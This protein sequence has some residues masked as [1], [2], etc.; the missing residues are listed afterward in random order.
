MVWLSALL[1]VMI[2]G[3]T[4]ALF[5]YTPAFHKLIPGYKNPEEFAAEREEMATQLAEMENQMER[6]TTYVASFRKLAGME[7]DSIPVFS[8]ARL[9]SM[10]VASEGAIIRLQE[11]EVATHDTSTAKAEAVR[12]L[13]VATKA[14]ESRNEPERQIVYVSDNQSGS[15]LH[16]HFPIMQ[17]LFS[18]ISGEIRKSF[19]EKSAHYGVDIVAE[20]NTLI[21]SVA[22]GFVIISEYS[23]DNG[24]VI[25]VASAENV[26]TFYKHN[27]RLLKD[28][29]TYVYA[30][31]PIA[32]IGN[33]GENSTGPHLHLELWRQGRPVD[34]TNYIEF[35]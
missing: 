4:A 10:R 16:R 23:D 32:V 8:D 21:R 12:T 31:E 1:F 11:E 7:G 29:G 2:V 35:N 18:P 24:W 28:A 27:S 15:G 6:W 14:V 19:D 30:G 5:V 9:D 22:D 33:T 13:P 25:G 3:G 20:E 26:V 34:P 17:N